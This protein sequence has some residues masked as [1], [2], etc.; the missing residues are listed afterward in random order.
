MAQSSGNEVTIE[1]GQSAF[2]IERPYIISVILSNSD[3]RPTITFPDIPG[4]SKKGISRSVTPSEVAGK[5][6]I[7]Q[8]IS[9]SYQARAPGRFRLPPFTITV[10]GDVARS[11]GAIL[12]VQAP[13]ASAPATLTTSASTPVVSS[14][15]LA[16][17][18]LQASRPV[19]YSG[20]GVALTLSF[21][22]GR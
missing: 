22:C 10:D 16:F 3:S 2:P 17:L 6:V 13:V 1:L 7:S 4:F 18:S 8:I 15:E 11:E 14:K 12:V 9:Q 5:T 19:I 21:F 20:E